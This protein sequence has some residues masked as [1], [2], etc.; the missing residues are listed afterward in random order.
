M[1]AATIPNVDPEKFSEFK[2]NGSN[3]LGY[4]GIHTH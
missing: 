1:S 2:M 3:S 4:V